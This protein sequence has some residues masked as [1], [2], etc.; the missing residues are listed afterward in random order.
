[1]K[2][3]YGISQRTELSEVHILKWKH[4]CRLLDPKQEK[5]YICLHEE[6]AQQG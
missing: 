5:E 4:L 2:L 3:E 1:M 6:M